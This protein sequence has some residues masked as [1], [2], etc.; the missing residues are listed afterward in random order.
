MPV[1]NSRLRDCDG[2]PELTENFN[3]V[4]ALVDAN[5]DGV[6]ANTSGIAS[7][8]AGAYIELYLAE[9]SNAVSIPTGSTYTAYNTVTMTC[10]KSNGLTLI[11]AEE[12]GAQTIEAETPGL[13]YLNATFCSKLGTTD[14]IWDTAIFVNGAEAT[15]LHMRRRFS[16]SG[17]AFN[18][19]LSGIVQLA[20]G[21]VI[22]VRV[23]HNNG[24]DVSITTEYANIS[25]HKIAAVPEA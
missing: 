18:V 22:D 24:S 5:A 17:Y 12:G 4:L 8:R 21:D 9:N 10:D 11:T 2:E 13:Y 14:V 1:I 15:N 6:E 23:K 3:R 16:T 25:L 7:L 19:S 20:V